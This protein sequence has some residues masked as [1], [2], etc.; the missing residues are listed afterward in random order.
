M[1][2]LDISVQE[3]IYIAMGFRGLARD[4]REYAEKATSH[5]VKE[6]HLDAAETYDRL[7]KKY[8][9]LSKKR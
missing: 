3:L 5:V 7:A 2:H 9:D 8:D 1:P 6:H 4:E